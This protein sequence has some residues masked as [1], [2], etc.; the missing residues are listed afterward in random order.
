MFITWLVRLH[1]PQWFIVPKSDLP[2]LIKGL[3]QLLE[4]NQGIDWRPHVG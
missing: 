1:Q 2:D 3:T 4:V